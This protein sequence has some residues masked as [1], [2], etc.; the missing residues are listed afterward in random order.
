MLTQAY[1]LTHV[2]WVHP[3][4]IISY[5]SFAFVW[6]RIICIVLSFLQITEL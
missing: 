4:A 2:I 3:Y 5:N 6:T 1:M